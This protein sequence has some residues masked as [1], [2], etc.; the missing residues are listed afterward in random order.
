MFK[1]NVN[2]RKILEIENIQ[3]ILKIGYSTPLRN[4]DFNSYII[5][6]LHHVKVVKTFTQ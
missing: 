2:M 4:E 1:L 3:T 6:Y 5:I